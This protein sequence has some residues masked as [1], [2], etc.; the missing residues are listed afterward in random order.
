MLRQSILLSDKEIKRERNCA[1]WGKKTNSPHILKCLCCKINSRG[2]P[3][4]WLGIVRISRK[5]LAS[6]GVYWNAVGGIGNSL[7]DVRVRSF[8]AGNLTPRP[9]KGFPKIAPG[10][11]PLPLPPTAFPTD[12]FSWPSKG[13]RRRFRGFPKGRRRQGS[14]D[15]SILGMAWSG[16][17]GWGAPFLGRFW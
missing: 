14:E 1:L 17:R 2:T 12:G 8:C 13:A 3:F 15:S 11:P 10:R 5:L 6:K 9:E 7:P 16:S 4:I